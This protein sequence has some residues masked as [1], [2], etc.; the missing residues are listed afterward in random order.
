M[1]TKELTNENRTTLITRSKRDLSELSSESK[2]TKFCFNCHTTNV[3][4][5]VKIHFWKIIAMNSISGVE[6]LKWIQMNIW[7]HHS[8]IET[9]KG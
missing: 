7:L 9:I 1:K 6:S 3:R 8:E 4:K 5:R 2:R